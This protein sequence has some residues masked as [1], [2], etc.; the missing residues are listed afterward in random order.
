MDAAVI[1]YYRRLLKDGFANAGKIENPT[2]F[3]DTVSENVPICG[4]MESYLH[5]F[6]NIKEGVI[7]DIKYLCTCDPPANVAVEIFC[8]LACGQPVDVVRALAPIAFFKVL[9]Q[10]SDELADRVNGLLELVG[11][12]LSRQTV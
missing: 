12:G 7:T 9:G 11:R 10:P 4:N 5:L 2:L 3:L 8:D 6:I 1:R